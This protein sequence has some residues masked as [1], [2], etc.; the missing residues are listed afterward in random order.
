V[1]AIAA[2]WV[3]A[4]AGPLAGC[5]SG[6]P[7]LTIEQHLAKLAGR[8]LSQTELDDRLELADLL[9]GFDRRV[10]E[11]IWVRLDA[12]ELE[13][14]DF[15]FGEH[16]PERISSY[17]EVRPSTGAVAPADQ[18]PSMSSILDEIAPATTE[19]RTTTTGRGATTTTSGAGGTS[20]TSGR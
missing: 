14:Q 2:L 10:L 11:R 6:E 13:F 5:A 1:L 8:P 17:Q 7:D 4:L 3:A 20:S 9:C 12:R 19:R 16:C 15:V 18:V